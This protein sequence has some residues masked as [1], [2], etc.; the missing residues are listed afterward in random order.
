MATIVSLIMQ[1]TFAFITLTL[2]LAVMIGAWLGWLIAAVLP[3]MFRGMVH[4]LRYLSQFVESMI[5]RF[6]SRT[7]SA[8]QDTRD[9]SDPFTFTT[10]RERTNRKHPRPVVKSYFED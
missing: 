8:V 1:L 2:R 10:K 5:G 6:R 3:P 9:A 4:G 7:R